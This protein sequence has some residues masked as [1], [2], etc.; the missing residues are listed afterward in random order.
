[1][2]AEENDV[3]PMQLNELRSQQPEPLVVDVR[4]PQQYEAGHVAGARNIPKDDL[5]QVLME[6]PLNRTIVLYCDMKHP[7]SSRSEQA[8]EM[9][10]KSGYVAR[11]L[12][13][14]FPAWQAAGY[15]VDT[16]YNG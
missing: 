5:L 3:S 16:G 7:G 4:D 13:G 6:P 10:R 8:A 11:V 14:G 2:V 9:L 1:M 15:P 12:Q